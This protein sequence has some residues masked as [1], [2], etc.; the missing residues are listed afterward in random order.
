MEGLLAQLDAAW[1]ERFVDRFG[2]PAGALVAIGV[3]LYWAARYFGPDVKDSIRAH[4]TLVTTL[5]ETVPTLAENAKSQTELIREG[6][7]ID[8]DIVREISGV[9]EH[10]GDLAD[11][12]AKNS[13]PE[14][15]ENMQQ[16]AERIKRRLKS[17]NP[18]IEPQSR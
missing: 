11:A 2:L 17:Q 1:F 7:R 13:C 16:H 3:F 6:R 15:Q 4:K 18:N 8:S 14:R 12:V 10:I 5:S 9:K